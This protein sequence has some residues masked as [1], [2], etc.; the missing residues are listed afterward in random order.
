MISYR[1]IEVINTVTTLLCTVEHNF[2]EDWGVEARLGAVTGDQWSELWAIAA[3]ISE[4]A[5]PGEWGGGNVIDRTDDGHNVYAMR[6]I[7]Y[8][9]PVIG[10]EQLFYEMDLVVPCE[11]VLDQC[12]TIDQL[13]WMDSASIADVVRFNSFILRGDRF[14]EGFSGEAIDAGAIAAIVEKLKEWR[15]S[16]LSA[17]E[18]ASS[19][20]AGWM[21]L[22]RDNCRWQ[23]AK[24]G[25]PHEYTIRDW[26]READKDFGRAA[27][28]IRKFGYSRSFYRN[29][30]IYFNLD[31]LK[32]WTMGDPLANT[33]VLNRDPIENK[34]ES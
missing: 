3:A 15:K 27:V 34:Y 28:G 19:E 26:R 2:E 5:T 1:S 22:Y 13:E 7:I 8:A 16:Q 21:R 20:F 33:S 25:P 11:K 30:Y 14:G 18:S 24:S 29:A 6:F 10:Y 4:L 32:Y 17:R 9:E 23:I 31:G 12:R